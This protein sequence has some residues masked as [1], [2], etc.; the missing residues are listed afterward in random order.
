MSAIGRKDPATAPRVGALRWLVPALLIVVWLGL[1]G[2]LGAIGGK[3]GEVA[4]SGAATYLPRNA[5][6]TEVTRLNKRFGEPETLPALVVYARDGGLTDADRDAIGR[7]LDAVQ[8]ELGGALA[9]APVG[10][11]ISDDGNAAEVIVP[12]A[13]TD[14]NEITP[15]V[16]KLRALLSGEDGMTVHV[17]GPAGVQADLKDALGAIDLMLLLV[18][19]ALILAILIVVYRSPLLPFLVLT[20]AGMAL[21]VAQGV[22]YLLATRDVLSLG[23]EVQGILNVLVLGAATDYA[24]L[25]VSR[26]REELRRHADR[27]DAMRVAWRRSLGP[28]LASG[29]TVALGLLC[30]LVSD[31]SLNR[32]LGPAGAIG[33]G[34]AMLAMLTLMPLILVL[35]G[36]VAF[37]PRRPAHNSPQAELT[38]A[39]SRVARSVDRRPRLIWIGTTV[40]LG[41]LA[42]GLVRLDADGIPQNEMIIGEKVESVLGQEELTRHFPAGSGSPV[43]VVADAGKLADVAAAAERVEG[44]AAVAPYTGGPAAAPAPGAPPPAPLV[45]DGL[46]RADVTLEY[47]PDSKQALDTLE[48]LRDALAAVPDADAKAGGYT[49]VLVDFNDAATKDRKVIPLLLLVVC[50]VVALLLRSVVASVLL[51]ATVVLSYLAAIGVS[52]VVF[53]DVFG[54]SAVDSTFPLHAF[55]FLV[56]LGIDYNIF[57]MSRV[58][59]ETVGVGTRRGMVTGLAV[60]GGVIT[61]AGV[62]LAATFAALAVI[63]LVLLVELAFTVAFGVLLDTFVV[64]SLLVPALTIDVGRW[65]WWPGRL[66]RLPQPG[67]G[68]PAPPPPPADDDL[69]TATAG[70]AGAG[71]HRGADS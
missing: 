12:F 28:I 52:A 46:A 32:D 47:A 70:A 67:G 17:T 4:E 42:L 13:G 57:L 18:T 5:E 60:T 61:S 66:A 54:F 15:Y 58:R 6:A 29:G 9:G 31:L 10:P 49:A 59:E 45:V 8:R 51:L 36:R 24:L 56:A 68:E 1:G 26:Y 53:R 39:W 30:L 2:W 65:M 33:I 62:V 69:V 25:L 7:Q 11:V 20:V 50:L 23:A 34:C 22:I 3:L 38:G 16:S 19:S 71:E 27:F 44:V 48:R 40:V 14:E 37:W 63:P 64:R 43:I 35:L 41:I 55:V 21:G